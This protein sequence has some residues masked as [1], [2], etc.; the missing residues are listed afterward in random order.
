MHVFLRPP[1]VTG[2]ESA[3]RRLTAVT[4]RDSAHTYSQQ[5][6]DDIGTRVSLRGGHPSQ[7]KA[8]GSMAHV[9]MS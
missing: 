2:L 8:I 3:R 6:R 7:S 4:A 9:R 1:G 5:R